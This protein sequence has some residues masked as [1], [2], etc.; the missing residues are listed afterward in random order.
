MVD[1]RSCKYQCNPSPGPVTIHLS[2]V[3]S[4][5]WMILVQVLVY[6]F[7]SSSHYPSPYG[8]I[9]PVDYFLR[10]LV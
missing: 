10:V 8:R 4:R 3:E 1:K 6:S 5:P 7:S 2:I 9:S